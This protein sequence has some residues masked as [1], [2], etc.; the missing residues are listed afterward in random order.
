METH[1][2]APISPQEKTIT[3][4][5]SSYLDEQLLRHKDWVLA[6]SSEVALL[7]SVLDKEEFYTHVEFNS[8]LNK[9]TIESSIGGEGAACTFENAHLI[10]IIWRKNAWESSLPKFNLRKVQAEDRRQA[11]MLMSE[12]V[13]KLVIAMM[14]MTGVNDR[15]VFEKKAT[16]AIKSQQWA[17][18]EAVWGVK[19]I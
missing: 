7:L 4:R 3:F 11:A 10:P 12:R 17:K 6:P 1:N 5:L 19:L 15:D 16:D 2:S 8:E 18:I 9:L 13:N 14:E